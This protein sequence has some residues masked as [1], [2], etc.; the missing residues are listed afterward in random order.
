MQPLG[1]QG[2]GLRG[3]EAVGSDFVTIS[4]DQWPAAM[5]LPAVGQRLPSKRL[6]E[7]FEVIR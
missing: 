5:Q 1:D 4:R 7:E 3:D 6:R 2:S